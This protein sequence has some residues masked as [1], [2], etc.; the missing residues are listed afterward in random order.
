MLLPARFSHCSAGH[1]VLEIL[2]YAAIYSVLCAAPVETTLAAAVSVLHFG[3]DQP[4]F[5]IISPVS[6]SGL[7][8]G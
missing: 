2:I 5:Y 4:N 7:M 1:L 3:L 8:A 6:R